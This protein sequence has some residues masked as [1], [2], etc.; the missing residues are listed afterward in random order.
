MNSVIIRKEQI[1]DSKAVLTQEQSKHLLEIVKVKV[2][3]ELKGTILEEGLTTITVSNISDGIVEVEIG[4]VR[5]GLHFLIELIIAASRP[6]TMKKVFEHCSAMGASHFHIF[7]AILSDK[8]YLTSKVYERFQELSELGV[9]QSAVFYKAPTLK[10]TYQYEDIEAKGVQRFILSP[11]ATTKL[12][13]VKID[14]E[15]PLQLA[16]GPERGWTNQEINEFKNLGFEEIS[17]GPSIMRVENA[18]IAIL[19]HL[20]QLMDRK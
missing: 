11:Y 4:Q 20:N 15:R 17:I 6:P 3:D 8:S 12:K 13:D 16:I 9:S 14:I 18:S 7:K 1:H 10:K 2:G 5:K 19:G